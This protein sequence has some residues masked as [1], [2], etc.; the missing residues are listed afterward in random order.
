MSNFPIW[1]FV[2]GIIILFILFGHL[3]YK[4]NFKLTKPSTL[5]KKYII[6][7]ADDFGTSKESD[8]AIVELLTDGKISSTTG[9]VNGEHFEA[10]LA[11][12]KE[13]NLTF[14]LGLHLVI[15]NNGPVNNVKPAKENSFLANSDG[16]FYN[17]IDELY[18]H[19][20]K[21]EFKQYWIKTYIT[22]K[23]GNDSEAEEEFNKLS[24]KDSEKLRISF[25]RQAIKEE[26]HEQFISFKNYD[27][28]WPINIDAHDKDVYGLNSNKGLVNEMLA[29]ANNN[30]SMRWAKYFDQSDYVQSTFK[31]EEIPTLLAVSDLARLKKVSI[32][33]YVITL[34]HSPTNEVTFEQ[35]KQTLYNKIK[36]I[37]RG[38]SEVCISPSTDNSNINQKRVWDY[39]IF[40]DPSFQ[41]FLNSNKITL[42]T[43]DELKKM[44]TA[45]SI[46]LAHK[47]NAFNKSGRG[48]NNFKYEDK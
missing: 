38:V 33:D 16:Y 41:V 3:Q 1:Y 21:E 13:K 35:Y 44:K 43:Y 27:N 6:I 9:V 37:K 11:M 47:I 28:L 26:W 48:Y 36:N 2:I 32:P 14:L 15:T 45:S 10:G 8:E 29:V 31:K 17:S 20:G 5:F 34:D 30:G 7:N 23:K 18:E 46:I 42:I 24:I 4:L 39:E 40:S 19:A 25:I 12:L 22:N